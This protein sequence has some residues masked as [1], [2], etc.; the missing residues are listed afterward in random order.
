MTQVQLWISPNTVTCFGACTDEGKLP[1]IEFQ[2]FV[3]FMQ[4]KPCKVKVELEQTAER[5]RPEL[6]F[7][8]NYLNSNFPVQKTPLK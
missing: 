3:E 1:R 5:Q 2:D 4:K 8:T 6:N 7:K